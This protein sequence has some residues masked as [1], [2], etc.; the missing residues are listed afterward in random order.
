[1]SHEVMTCLVY[2]HLLYHS[3]LDFPSL[4]EIGSSVNGKWLSLELVMQL[5]H[6][7]E[8]LEEMRWIKC[9]KL[10]TTITMTL[11]AWKCSM[12]CKQMESAT[13]LPVLY[14]IMMQ[15]C[16]RSPACLPCFLFCTSP[17]IQL[18]QWSALEIKHMDVHDIFDWY[19]KPWA[20][21]TNNEE[22]AA[23]EV[24]DAQNKGPRSGV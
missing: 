15:W 10:F 24:K 14:I 2:T 21:L 5:L 6:L 17:M 18:G 3:F 16:F 13:H 19:I 9:N 23:A 4:Q 12:H 1:M 22:R 20:R 7:Y 11:Q 8:Q